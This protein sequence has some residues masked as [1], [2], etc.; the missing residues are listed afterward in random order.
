MLTP[1][2]PPLTCRAHMARAGTGVLQQYALAMTGPFSGR[3][4][5][6]LSAGR[7]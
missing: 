4:G 7:S 1:H 6:D 5:Q 3:L 2:A